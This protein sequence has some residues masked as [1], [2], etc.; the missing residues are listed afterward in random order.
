MLLLGGICAS[1]VSLLALSAPPSD[2]VI[3]GAP[4]WIF[5]FDARNN[6]SADLFIAGESQPAQLLGASVPRANDARPAWAP[7]AV[8]Y[9]EGCV[10]VPCTA[11]QGAGFT[12]PEYHP[13]G[14]P[15][16]S[17]LVT[18]VTVD[19]QPV[20]VSTVTDDTITVSNAP[21]PSDPSAPSQTVCVTKRAGLAAA[22]GLTVSAASPGSDADTPGRCPA[23]PLAFQSNRTENYEIWVY[24]PALDVGP[25]NPVNLTQARR[26]HETAPAWSPAQ[27][28]TTDPGS[29]P[30]S[31]LLAFESDRRGSRDIFVLNPALPLSDDRNAP[32]PAPVTTSPADDANPEWSLDGGSI[33]FE[34]DRQGP[35]DIWTVEVHPDAAGRFRPEQG[36]HQ[37]TSDEQPAYDPT[38]YTYTNTDEG[39]TGPGEAVAFAGPVADDGECQLNAVAWPPGPPPAVS[40][41][42]VTTAEGPQ[43]DS[44]AFSPLGTSVATQSGLG[45]QDIAIFTPDAV[46]TADTWSRLPTGGA[47][48]HAN[49]QPRYYTAEWSGKRPIGRAHK[50]KK[51]QKPALATAAAAPAARCSAPPDAAFRT[52]PVSPQPE[53]RMVLDAS[54]SS[55]LH[56]RIEAY[57]W[58]LDGDGVFEERRTVPTLRWTFSR[59]RHRV[60]L[61]VLDGDGASA[62]A[63]RTIAVGVSKSACQRLADRLAP[64]A[65]V[66]EGD[67][68]RTVRRGTRRRD[69]MCGYGGNDTLYAEG[70]NDI[71]VG[72]SG[73]DRLFGGQGGDRAFG[74]GGRDYISGG[75]GN[76]RCDGGPNRDRL[77]GGD[78]VDRLMGGSG[79]DR[80]YGE[81]GRDR[82]LA[83]DRL[84][85]VVS[86]GPQRDRARVDR[87]DKV[88]RV[89]VLQR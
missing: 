20:D 26:S 86:G 62:R 47:A 59:G 29:P 24:D 41:L 55:D 69:V 77:W 71:I 72:G 84:R 1:L 56:G 52:N 7:E 65:N 73:N 85:D 12:T 28:G 82:L 61:R 45:V 13:A 44:P 33:V 30:A 3:R 23:Q 53:K 48:R 9:V 37:L 21:A 14:A 17:D 78:A 81:R 79:R 22:P 60:A 68:G 42:E 15:S 88:T 46:G 5:A 6:G 32:N 43:S 38:W 89:E 8:M 54:A 35:K 80:M 4:S 63:E 40:N 49:W 25:G 18:G 58:D 74:E 83:R 10:A 2:A 76:D 39:S 50:R 31:P 87:R 67:N 34:S 64:G 66:I 36:L 16:S 70:G 75:A 51:R 19:G 11:V 57:E 27:G